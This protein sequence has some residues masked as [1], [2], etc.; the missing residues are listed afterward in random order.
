M[1]YLTRHGQTDW[2]LFKRANGLTDTF[3]NITGIEQAKEMA[4]KL[5][6]VVFDVCFCSPLTRA[7][8]FAEIV[9]QG[10]IVFDNRLIEINCGDYEGM[11]ETPEMM[12]ALWQSVQNGDKGTE[13]FETFKNRTYDLCDFISYEYKGKNVLI[14]THA[15]NARV[16]NHYF[17]GKPSDY[18]F[19]KGVAR[20]N[21]FLVFSN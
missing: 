17:V 5:S 1:I 10:D 8:Q 13:S 19:M 15:A 7:R 6:D 20:N 21:E 18:N 3:L 14:V 2:N 4:R 11:E 9:Y 16:I 12:Q